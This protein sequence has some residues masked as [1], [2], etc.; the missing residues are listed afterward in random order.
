[1][2]IR[3]LKTLTYAQ[4][5]LGSDFVGFPGKSSVP[6]PLASGSIIRRYI[7]MPSRGVGIPTLG[8]IGEEYKRRLSNAG[9]LTRIVRREVRLPSD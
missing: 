6:C 4:I 8:E 5:K 3:I 9:V 1:M 2:T 7:A